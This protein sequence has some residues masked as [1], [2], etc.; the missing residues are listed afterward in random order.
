M[1]DSHTDLV[2][3]KCNGVMG[4]PITALDKLNPDEYELIGIIRPIVQ[5]KAKYQRLLIR[6]K[7][8]I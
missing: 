4:V 8:K 2:S 3:K 7:Q 1:M 5:G 6:K